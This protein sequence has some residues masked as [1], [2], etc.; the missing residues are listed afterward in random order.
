MKTKFG[1]KSLAL[2][3]AVVTVVSMFGGMFT[4]SAAGGV[5][6]AD[7]KN[8]TYDVWDGSVDTDWAT[9]ATLGKLITSA[10][11]LAGL[12]SSVNAG[13][14][15]AGET[16]SI[17][18]NIDLGG[19]EWTAIGDNGKTF[20]GNLNGAY[21]KTANTAVIIK[22]MN[23]TGGSVDGYG[24]IGTHS[25][26]KVSY[27]TLVEPTVSR[28]KN[29]GAFFVGNATGAGSTYQN[30]IAIDGTLSFES[31]AQFTDIGGLIGY[32]DKS[33]VVDSCAIVNGSITGNVLR[34]GGLIGQTKAGTVAIKNT[35]TGARVVSSSQRVGGMIGLVE[36]S[37]EVSF[38]NCQSAGMV[39]S[40]ST[41]AGSWI[42][43]L[44]SSSENGT[45]GTK[46]SFTNCVNTGMGAQG[47][48]D[49]NSRFGWVGLLGSTG[50]TT[51]E[52]YITITTS[53]CYTNCSDIPM[54]PRNDSYAKLNV[55]IDGTNKTGS[56]E[57]GGNVVWNTKKATDVGNPNLPTTE[58][59][60]N[61]RQTVLNLVK[62]LDRPY[63]DAKLS[64]FKPTTS[65]T[66]FTIDE[67]SEMIG[68]ALLSQTPGF[69][70][71]KYS[72][73]IDETDFT[74]VMDRDQLFYEGFLES[75][76]IT[77]HTKNIEGTTVDPD[78]M[79]MTVQVRSASNGNENAYDIRFV[80][81]VNN[82]LDKYQNV[83]FEVTRKD[84]GK[85]IKLSTK[86]V[87]TYINGEN[88][89][90][91]AADTFCDDS[92]YFYA[93]IITNVPKDAEFIVRP[94]IEKL[95][96]GTGDRSYIYGQAKTI[97]Y[98]EVIPQQSN[99]LMDDIVNNYQI[100]YA[101]G[102]TTNRAVAVKLRD[103]ITLRTGVV[104]PI[105]DDTVASANG[106]K[107]LL[108]GN[109]STFDDVADTLDSR[110]EILIRRAK[111]NGETTDNVVLR[112]KGNDEGRN[113]LIQEFVRMAWEAK[114]FKSIAWN[115]YIVAN[116]SWATPS[117]TDTP[118][119]YLENF[120]SSWKTTVGATGSYNPSSWIYDFHEKGQTYL[121]DGSS[122]IYSKS[123]RGDTTYYPDCS[124]QGIASAILAGIDCVEFDVR[125]TLDGVPVV[126]HDSSLLS[127]TNVKEFA[128]RNIN[129]IQYPNSGSIEDWTYVQ[130]KS[131]DLTGKEASVNYG[132]ISTLYEVLELCGRRVFVQIDDKTADLA[133]GINGRLTGG[134]SAVRINDSDWLYDLTKATNSR[135]SLF[136]FYQYDN[137]GNYSTWKTTASNSSDVEDQ[138]FVK[139]YD[140]MTSQD[141]N[142]S[143]QPENCGWPKA[144]GVYGS[145]RNGTLDETSN[146]YQLVVAQ[147]YIGI[148]TENPYVLCQYIQSTYTNTSYSSKPTYGSSTESSDQTQIPVDGSGLTAWNKNDS[149]SVGWGDMFS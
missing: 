115:T 13:N 133:N 108:I 37:V 127:T 147:N 95:Y 96:S 12:A 3:L 148:W 50:S 54:F 91:K 146:R 107:C 60:L 117:I 84:T 1:R 69:P 104:M 20:A 70:V 46:V 113:N 23:I 15:Y 65:T 76:N 114:D 11:E 135:E 89:K 106:V 94:F 61:G 82:N 26:A 38:T 101:N 28:E 126:Q 36:K 41:Q 7:I 86:K 142:V 51:V 6:N 121:N 43:R 66:S 87:Y 130:L 125:F 2:V 119:K 123:H 128:G 47:Y 81:T 149:T 24:L 112:S 143:N 42:G 140:W 39:G 29:K 59:T 129:G 31:T 72:Y 57:T 10:A 100:V 111:K 137:A 131:L 78:V 22:G 32:A 9:D 118:D 85:T 74:S 103:A 56:T 35:Y 141:N 71:A 14:T 109:I 25:G 124:L 77:S 4:V 8:A 134:A 73:T 122:R 116:D 34:L 144:D 63:A 55:S 99:A 105:V 88:V 21:G 49:G 58:W 98:N 5:S 79:A 27:I 68:L 33:L 53:S 120:Y 52:H 110:Y 90:Y 92:A 44:Q 62:N 132:K 136:L 45:A 67:E 18:V 139:F 40:V 30:L 83:G 93:Q 102:N 64:W 16:F 17:T 145:L 19:R 80:S 97:C 138:N 75:I 48:D